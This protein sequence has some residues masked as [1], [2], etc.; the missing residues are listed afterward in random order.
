MQGIA[1]A[2]RAG[3]TNPLFDTTISIYPT[4]VEEFVT[5]REASLED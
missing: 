2:L 4:A 5:M 1:I 3:A